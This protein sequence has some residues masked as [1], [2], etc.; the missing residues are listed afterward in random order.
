MPTAIAS[1]PPRRPTSEAALPESSRAN[2]RVPRNR[3]GRSG[4][5]QNLRMH[6][7]MA[8]R[9]DGRSSRTLAVAQRCYVSIGG[10]AVDP[11][12]AAGGVERRLAAA[13]AHMH[14]IPRYVSAPGAVRMAEHGARPL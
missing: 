13:L 5:K 11:A 3:G 8:M 4:A 7:R 12:D 2:R 10:K 9:E 14:R 1:T 6:L